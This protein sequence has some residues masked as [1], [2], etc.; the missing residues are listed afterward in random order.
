[1][2]VEMRGS[3]LHI[4]PRTWEAFFCT[5]HSEGIPS[6]VCHVLC[7]TICTLPYTCVHVQSAWAHV[8]DARTHSCASRLGR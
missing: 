6:R 4:E 5:Q 8:C 1:M 2:V 7:F 3:L